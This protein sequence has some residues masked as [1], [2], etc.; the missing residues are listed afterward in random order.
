MW[1]LEQ[2]DLHTKASFQ[3]MDSRTF[4]GKKSGCDQQNSL[5]D[6]EHTGRKKAGKQNTDAK[7]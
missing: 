3:R 1:G 6:N 7:A 5:Q 4:Q 2:N